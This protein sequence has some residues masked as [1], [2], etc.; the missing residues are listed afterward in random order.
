MKWFPS[1]SGVVWF[2][3]LAVVLGFWPVAVASAQTVT[4]V[5]FNRFYLNYPPE[6]QVHYYSTDKSVPNEW[7][8]EGVEGY[9]SPTP[10]SYTTKL[11]RFY[12]DNWVDHVYTASDVEAGILSHHALYRFEL[13]AGYVVP[14]DRDIPGTVPLYRFTR[15]H[16]GASRLYQDHF[17][18]LSSS[19]PANYIAE[20]ICC[21]VW[22][23]PVQLPDALLK[24]TGPGPNQKWSEGSAQ[25][26][27]WQIWTGGGFMRL[28]YS[29]N[30][31]QS[32]SVIAD[33]PVPR[34]DG[35]VANGSYVWHLPATLA[36]M[37]RIRLDWVPSPGATPVPWASAQSGDVMV[38]R[39]LIVPKS[40]KK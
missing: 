7:L 13:T 30:N 3:A 16:H 28:S 12:N 29:T 26:L 2:V 40:R 24:M 6:A 31:G 9:V 20:G 38:A 14:A 10:R 22:K 23:D 34:N 15:S 39:V 36:G 37:I 11:Q 4:A 33:V 35:V 21:R 19:L 8:F 27:A 32:W 18:S 1:K 25:T 17:Y 5:A